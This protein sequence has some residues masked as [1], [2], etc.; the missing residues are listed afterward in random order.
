MGALVDIARTNHVQDATPAF[1]PVRHDQ[2][3]IRDGEATNRD[4]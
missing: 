4:S 3:N 2:E 1:Q